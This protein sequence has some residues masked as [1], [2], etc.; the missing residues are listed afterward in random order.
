MALHELAHVQPD[1][2]IGVPKVHVRER[3]GELGLPDAG[4]AAEEEAADGAVRILQPRAVAHHGARDSADGLRLPHHALR[5]VVAEVAKPVALALLHALHWDA[6]PAGNHGLNVLRADH[7]MRRVLRA[8]RRQRLLQLRLAPEKQGRL[9]VQPLAYCI[10]LGAHHLLELVTTAEHDITLLA[11][12][13]QALVGEEGVDARAAAGLVQ[14]VDGL[15]GHVAVC[16]VAV[17]QRDR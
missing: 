9:L 7:G 12:R 11:N 17:R 10:R 4:G 16:D 8:L 2:G 5:K 15:V 13:V 1:H 6:C 3:L 14:Q